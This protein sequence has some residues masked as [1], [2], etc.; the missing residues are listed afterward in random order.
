MTPQLW[1]VI[2]GFLVGFAMMKVH[3]IQAVRARESGD[4][5]MAAVHNALATLS[6]MIWAAIGWLVIPLF[7]PEAI[8][9]GATP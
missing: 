7:M 2:V 3:R 5:T 1:G 9:A 4:G 8:V 6:T